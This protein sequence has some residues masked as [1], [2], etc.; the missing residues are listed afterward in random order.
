MATVAVLVVG[1]GALVEGVW[2]RGPA[3]G[4]VVMSVETIGG[5]REREEEE[6]M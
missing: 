4:G 1:Y 5:C 2:S 6:E 3:V